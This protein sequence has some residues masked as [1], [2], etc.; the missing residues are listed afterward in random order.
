MRY[1]M[2]IFLSFGIGKEASVLDPILGAVGSIAMCIIMC[3][4]TS[5][6]AMR[7]CARWVSAHVAASMRLADMTDRPDHSG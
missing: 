1:Y 5:V 4:Y 3:I 6:N 7:A 2:Y